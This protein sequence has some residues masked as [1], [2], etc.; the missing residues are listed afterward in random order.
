[1]QEPCW[2]KGR[3]KT[4]IFG[5]V[6]FFSDSLSLSTSLSQPLSPPLPPSQPLSLSVS[7]S[8]YNGSLSPTW[9][10]GRRRSRSALC[11]RVQANGVKPSVVH[12]SCTPQAAKVRLAGP[13]VTTRKLYHQKGERG[14]SENILEN[15]LYF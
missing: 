5:S 3:H 1:M 12:A 4:G 11:R 2:E 6:N 9:E 13:C 10:K 14:T 8:R 7:L 15:L